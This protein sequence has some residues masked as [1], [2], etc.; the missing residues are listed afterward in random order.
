MDSDSA[1][2]ASAVRS[3]GGGELFWFSAEVTLLSVPDIFFFLGQS[4]LL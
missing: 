3:G 1:I 4:L 2:N